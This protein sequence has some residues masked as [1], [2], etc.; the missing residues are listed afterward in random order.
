MKSSQASSLLWRKWEILILSIK[1]YSLLKYNARLTQHLNLLG[2][3][4]SEKGGGQQVDE[5]YC[6]QVKESKGN[7]FADCKIYPL[8]YKNSLFWMINIEINR[9]DKRR[10]LSC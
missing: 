3:A 5:S 2:S 9:C 1:K 8:K 7:Y 4:W 10:N 6:V